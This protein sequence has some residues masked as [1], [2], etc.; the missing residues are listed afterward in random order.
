MAGHSL[1]MM[2]RPM[3]MFEAAKKIKTWMPAM[4]AGMT[5]RERCAILSAVM[6]GL[7][8]RIH[9]FDAGEKKVDVDTRKIAVW[10][11]VALWTHVRE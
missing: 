1:S 4:N 7:D 2:F 5:G 9:V 10:K 8:P 3:R 11:N 6:R